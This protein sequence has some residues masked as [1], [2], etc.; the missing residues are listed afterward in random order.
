MVLV[1][2]RGSR[3]SGARVAEQLREAF[4]WAQDKKHQQILKCLNLALE[5]QDACLWRSTLAWMAMLNSLMHIQNLE[6]CKL[7]I[8]KSWI[9]VEQID[10]IS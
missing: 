7:L 9:F 10:K 6:P 2:S 1:R 3:T 5:S 4:P 8:N